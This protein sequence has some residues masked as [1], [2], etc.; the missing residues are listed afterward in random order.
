[1]TNI[2][3]RAINKNIPRNITARINEI[4]GIQ[5]Q[6]RFKKE[7]TIEEITL[8]VRVKS[9]KQDIIA[10]NVKYFCLAHSFVICNDFLPKKVILVK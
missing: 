5:E 7:T 10:Q 4:L 3:E 9:E 1:V 8:I 6:E 2:R